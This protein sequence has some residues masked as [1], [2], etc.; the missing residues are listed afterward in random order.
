MWGRSG[1]GS[2]G[3]MTN[4][5]ATH[6]AF[7]RSLNHM[8]LGADDPI[9]WGCSTKGWNCCI[10]KGIVVRPYDMVRL[11]HGLSKP[12]H[13]ITAE[14]TVTFAWH[15]PTGALVGSLAHKPY[16][17]ASSGSGHLACT[18]YDEITNRGA[19]R[20]REGDPERFA[21]MPLTVQRAAD[22]SA[23][24]EYRVAGLCQAHQN[25]PEVCR[26]FPF[27]RNTS[28]DDAGVTVEHGMMRVNACG[29]CALS[30]PTTPRQTVEN[31]DIGEYWRANDVFS[32]VTA[33]FR[34]RGAAKPDVAGYQTL[35]ISETELAELWGSM[36]LVDRDPAVVAQFS[37]QWQLNLDIDGDREVYRVIMEHALDRLDA[38]V[39]ASGLALDQLGAPGQSAVTRPDLD[40]MLDPTRPFL[41]LQAVA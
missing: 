28:V 20:M 31:E 18:F 9:H 29:S 35:P 19:A 10:D 40:A 34:V 32:A 41:M 6:A 22:A 17:T 38:A 5:H 33:Y 12:A 27:Q 39:T 26:A 16:E 2:M 3:A 13:E 37:E 15:G 25:R 23:A 7:G 4:S 8:A 14:N 36:Y 11:R 30:T 24:N 1:L 21:S